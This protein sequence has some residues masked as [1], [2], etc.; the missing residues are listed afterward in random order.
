MGRFGSIH[1]ASDI[2]WRVGAGKLQ[3]SLST[4]Q[5]ELS[6]ASGV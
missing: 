4:D 1:R 6:R 3:I 2:R 5:V